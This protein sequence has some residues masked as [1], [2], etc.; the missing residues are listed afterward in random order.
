MILIYFVHYQLIK[1]TMSFTVPG[2]AVL[3]GAFAKE[4]SSEKPCILA[5]NTTNII[6]CLKCTLKYIDQDVWMH[7]GHTCTGSLCEGKNIISKD[8]PNGLSRR[9]QHYGF[10]YNYKNRSKPLTATRPFSSNLAVKLFAEILKD[11]FDN[12]E[13]PTQCIINEYEVGQS[14]SPHTDHPCF[15]PV[16]MTVTLAGSGVME[17]SCKGKKTEF[18]RL[19]AGDIVLLEDEARTTY[20]HSISPIVTSDVPEDNPRRV[21]LTLRTIAS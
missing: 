21:S 17:M 7:D 13:L 1:L 10:E 12:G 15:G 18:I 20:K 4:C 9:T 6:P 11:N 2:L 14:I 8:C 5:D 3:R 19:E 16:I